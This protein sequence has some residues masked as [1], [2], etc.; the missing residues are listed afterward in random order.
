MK[1]LKT[2]KDYNIKELLGIGSYGK[3]YRVTKKKDDKLS[4][5]LKQISLF[6][7]KD[8]EIKEVKNEAKLLSS[9]NSRYI[10]KYYESWVENG[11]LNII[12]E[13]CEKGDLSKLIK[14][15]S[16][17]GNNNGVSNLLNNNK[18]TGLPEE[19]IWNILV[20]MCIGLNY[21][22]SKK[23]LHR[24][25][26]TQNILITK[27]DNVKIGDLG[28]AKALSHTTF[29]KTFVGTPYYLSPEIC[30]E[31]PYNEKSDIWALG[32]CIYQM[33]TLKHPFN[34]SS[35][36]ALIMKIL[37]DKYLPIS[38]EYSPELH[39]LIDIMLEKNHFVRPKIGDI[40]RNPSKI[41]FLIYYF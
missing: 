30:E 10:V 34:A 21:L 32:C 37:R 28:V 19:K 31:K 33:S 41:F 38:I 2:I 5:V 35:Q 39:S 20:Q 22:H 27:N 16:S 9:L 17:N 15:Y 11:C 36:P 18:E 26:K 24:D 8:D 13:F 25:L 1:K 40:L 14:E 23:I 4:L 6:N 12:M 29:A 7:M 3:V